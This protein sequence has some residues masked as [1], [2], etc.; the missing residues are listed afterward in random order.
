MKPSLPYDKFRWWKVYSLELIGLYIN[1]TKVNKVRGF[2]RPIVR[3]ADRLE[4]E[5]EIR[6]LNSITTLCGFL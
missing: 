6:Y 3:N 4:A 5:L 1:K 2:R